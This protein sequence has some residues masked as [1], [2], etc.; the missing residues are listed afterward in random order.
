M[1]LEGK[2]ALVTGAQQG[3]G[4]A[5]VLALAREGAD[6]A[7]NWFEKETEAKQLAEEVRALKRS[8]L[9]VQGD[10]SKGVD[11]TRLVDEAYRGLGGLDILINNAGVFPRSPFLQLT[12]A[13]WDH[14]LD[15]NLKGSF[16]VAQAVA[17]KMVADG[18]KGA[19]V[20]LSSSSVRGHVLGVHYAASKNGIIGITRSMA[21]ALAPH[22]I[23]VNAVAPGITDTAQPRYQFSEAEMAEQS[24]LVPLGSMASPADIADILVFLASGDARFMTGETVHA[25]GGLYMG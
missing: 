24:R 20:N 16:L 1:R 14:V 21:L 13:E 19:I 2:R 3:I 4:R 7:I 11:V 6:V 18:T 5:A 15:V 25:N 8:S 10:V 12:E 17:R 22:G 23:R 9:T